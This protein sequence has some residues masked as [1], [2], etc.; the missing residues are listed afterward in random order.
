MRKKNRITLP[1]FP[2]CTC[3]YELSRSLTPPSVN[4]VRPDPRCAFHCL[5]EELTQQE[6]HQLA[7]RLAWVEASRLVLVNVR[8]EQDR[9]M[10]S[11]YRSEPPKREP[12]KYQPFAVLA[13][14]SK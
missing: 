1:P 4:L 6:E 2:K 14:R 5:I 12:L 10:A 8:K 13:K 11:R 7:G 3:E 9:V